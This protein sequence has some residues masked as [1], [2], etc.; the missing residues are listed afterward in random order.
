MGS[1]SWWSYYVIHMFCNKNLDVAK[2]ILI[3]V[4]WCVA[5]VQPVSFCYRCTP[6]IHLRLQWCT[7][8]HWRLFEDTKSITWKVRGLPWLEI[9]W[10]DKII[11]QTTFLIIN[12][13][14]GQRAKMNQHFQ[15]YLH[16]N[17]KKI[18]DDPQKIILH[19]HFL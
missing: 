3:F 12:R 7:I 13:K 15:S 9:P 16:N 6:P 18:I 1:D 11:K 2:F 4:E 17:N 19:C 10:H 14:V 5:I 8:F